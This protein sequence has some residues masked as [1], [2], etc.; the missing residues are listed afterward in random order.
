MTVQRIPVFYSFHFDN[1][2]M[3]VQLI[4]NIGAIEGDQPVSANE[5]EAIKARGAGAVQSWIDENMKYKRCVIVLVGRETAYR[6]WV[7]YEIQRAWQ[8]GKG[9]FGVYVHNVRCARTGLCQQGGN[10]FDQF[11][12]DNG[13]Q[14]LSDIVPCYQ[15]NSND[16]YGSIAANMQ[17]WVNAA[18]AQRNNAYLPR[19]KA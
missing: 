8:S 18:I 16:A 3:R 6:P 4:R 12:M 14:R 17:S 9:L 15:P 13:W 10:P 2:V 19:L 1:D 5:W 11:D 7:R